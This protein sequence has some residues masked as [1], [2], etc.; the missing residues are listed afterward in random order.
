MACTL[1]AGKVEECCRRIRD[2]VNIYF[3]LYQ[4]IRIGRNSSKR[5]MDYVAD[6]FCSKFVFMVR[7]ITNGEIEQP[8][9][10]CVF[11]EN[12]DS[13]CNLGTRSVF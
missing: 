5:I 1:I 12:W 2:V 9:L 7:S 10:K 11:Y 8:R 3:W 6:V 4:E 13:M